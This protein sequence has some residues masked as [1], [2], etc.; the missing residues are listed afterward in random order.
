V[1][2][3]P[4]TRKT[5]ATYQGL[6]DATREELRRTGILVPE[7]VAEAAGVSPATLYAYFGSKDALLAA[8]FDAT[9]A[10]IGEEV[11]DILTVENLLEHGWEATA[12]HLVR[13][14]VKRFTHDARVVRLSVARLPDSEEVVEVY[15]RRGDEQLEMV[16][17]FIRLGITAG[18]LR[19]GDLTVLSKSLMVILQGMQNPLVL[20]PGSGPVV[21]ELTRTV[22]RLLAPD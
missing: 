3:L 1:P 19:K 6:I 21:D 16:A 13:T 4:A 9:L 17:R 2:T 5:R 15:R 10:Q 11:G 22:H 18:K 14:V 7:S 20:Q 12:R 8:A